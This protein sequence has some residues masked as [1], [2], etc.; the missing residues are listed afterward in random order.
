MEQCS[1]DDKASL[2]LR[3][4]AF[5][6]LNQSIASA[7][8]ASHACAHMWRLLYGYDPSGVT[9]LKCF[10]KGLKNLRP[11]V[12]PPQ[13]L[14]NE[15]PVGALIKFACSPPPGI[16]PL[17]H[18]LVSAVLA[19]GMRAMQR[20]QQI[21]DLECRD[22]STT[23]GSPSTLPSSS[24]SS[25]WPAG[26]MMKFCIRATKTDP[27]GSRPWTVV[28]EPGST[29]ADPLSLLDT[30][31]RRRFGVPITAWNASPW[32]TSTRY[33]FSKGDLR[34]SSAFLRT[35]VQSVASHAGL[36]G[37][38]GSHSLRISGACWAA[39]GGMTLET[40]MAIAGWKA[41]NSAVLYLRNVIGA[42]SGAS[43][44]MGL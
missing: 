21:S 42:F 13:P 5:L 15:L 25:L 43:S 8:E 20:G 38:F 17:L 24:S 35:W 23:L 41:S 27:N 26:F 44:R 18:A 1:N 22:V 30:Y 11:L 31:T 2:L 34:L 6:A 14:R 37:H 29:A 33:F 10:K 7:L 9:L 39:A 12:S 40:I 28:I 19:F 16:D 32:A 36:P 4:M 3:Y